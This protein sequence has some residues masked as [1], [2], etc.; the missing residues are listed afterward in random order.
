[1]EYIIIWKYHDT[2]VEHYELYDDAEERAYDLCEIYE[3]DNDFSMS[4][5]QARKIVV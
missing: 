3:S 5:Y 2:H 4:I 1:M